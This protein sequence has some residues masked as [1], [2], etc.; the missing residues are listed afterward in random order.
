MELGGWGVVAVLGLGFMALMWAIK[1]AR[2]RLRRGLAMAAIAAAVTG[3][4][5]AGALS[6]GVGGFLGPMGDTASAVTQQVEQIGDETIISGSGSGNR[7]TE[8]A[9]SQMSLGDAPAHAICAV[10][11]QIDSSMSALRGLPLIG[12]LVP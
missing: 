7:C 12:S 5:G 4:G 2:R 3:Y 10:E 1:A 9:G 11:R 6:L 8:L